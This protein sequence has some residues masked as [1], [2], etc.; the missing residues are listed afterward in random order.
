MKATAACGNALQADA[1]IDH[2][3]DR[4]RIRANLMMMV[5]TPAKIRMDVT[6]MNFLVATLTSDGRRFALAD[7]REKRFLVGPAS[8][9]NIARLTTVPLPGHALVSLL[10]GQAPI[11]KHAQGAGTIAWSGRGHYVVTL[12]STRDA[13]EE[14]HVT[15]RPDDLQKA[16]CDQRMRVLRVIVRQ[17][18]D[19]LYDAELSDHKPTAMGK[20]WVDPDGI[21]PPI[22]PSGEFCDAELP[23]KIHVDVPPQDEEVVFTY[24]NVVWNPPLRPDVFTQPAPPGLPIV[25]VRCE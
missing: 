19:V 12:P 6:S 15:P 3:G 1:K 8:A 5:A 16:W 22:P 24:E 25:P 17:Y 14:I 4:G 18:G 13:I 9:C 20:E 10:R 23:R 7:M 11:L 21:E 2:F